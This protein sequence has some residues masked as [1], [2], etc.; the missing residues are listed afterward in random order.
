MGSSLAS[1]RVIPSTKNA[2]LSSTHRPASLAAALPHVEFIYTPNNRKFDFVFNDL[3][4]PHTTR[5]R[6]FAHNM[7]MILTPRG[8]PT[9]ST[10]WDALR[11]RPQSEHKG[12]I[13]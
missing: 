8:R 3:S 5:E 9:R 11:L 2:A 1:A 10:P 13:T 6:I 12:R 7:S 4:P